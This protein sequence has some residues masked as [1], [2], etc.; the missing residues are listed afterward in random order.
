MKHSPS[1]SFHLSPAA[2]VAD[3]VAGITVGME[4]GFSSAPIFSAAYSFVLGVF[5]ALLL[6]SDGGETS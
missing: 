4:R 3:Y 2:T 5:F 1:S 6:P